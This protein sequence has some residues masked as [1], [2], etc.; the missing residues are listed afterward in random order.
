MS[1]DDSGSDHDGSERRSRP[2]RPVSLTR[3]GKDAEIAAWEELDRA[4]QRMGRTRRFRRGNMGLREQIACR[5]DEQKG[6][7]S[8]AIFC[9]VIFLILIA[10]GIYLN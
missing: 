9:G 6:D 1:S 8:G 7:L 10:A 5:R 4:Y 3:L 2:M